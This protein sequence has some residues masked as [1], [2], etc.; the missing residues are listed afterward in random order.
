MAWMIPFPEQVCAL[1]GGAVDSE[2]DGGFGAQTS[3]SGSGF[4]HLD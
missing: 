2:A 1:L 4:R 3:H